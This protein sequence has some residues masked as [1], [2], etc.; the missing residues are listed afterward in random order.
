LALYGRVV[1]LIDRAPSAINVIDI[2]DHVIDKG[3]VLDA[4]VTQSLIGI[5]LTAIEAHIVVVSIET[6]LRHSGA[7]A[8]APGASSPPPRRS[9]VHS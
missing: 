6:C 5:D 7:V 1:P 2:L 4:W 9:R 3:I 8:G